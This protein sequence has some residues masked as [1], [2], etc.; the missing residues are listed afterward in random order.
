MA[1]ISSDELRKHTSE[2]SAWV[3]IKG[4]VY[5][6]TKFL[7][8]HPGG[9]KVLLR[10]CGKDASKKFAMFHEDKVLRDYGKNMVVGTVEGSSGS[11]PKESREAKMLKKM[12]KGELYG[13]LVPFGDPPWYQGQLSPYYNDSHRRWRQKVRD[14]TEKEIMPFVSEWEENYAIPTEVYRKA[15]DAGLLAG[16][17]GHSWPTEYVGEGP[18][19]YDAFHTLILL[20]ELA[21]CGAGGLPWGLSGGLVIGLPPIINFGSTFLKDKVVTDCLMGRKII[22]LCISEPWAASDVA[23]LQTTAEKQGDNFVVNGCKKWIIIGLFA[24]YFTVACRTRGA[25]SPGAGQSMFLVEK[26]ML[27]IDPDD[28]DD[29]DN[30]KGKPST[31]DTKAKP[32]SDDPKFK[33]SS[34]NLKEKPN[35]DDPKFKPSSDNL[36]EKPNSD[37][38]KFKP[39][40]DN[41]KAKPKSD[42]PK[43]KPSSDDPNLKPSSDDPKF[44]PSS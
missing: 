38:P 15:G 5:D 23:G 18:E 37:D 24:D 13:D 35:S 7:G 21:R 27:V 30:P 31:D 22:C 10:E 36:K 26:M 17:V 9:K 40:S 1:T 6:V 34:D 4:T 11:R 20:D 16:C 44:K 42:D 19:N 8:D 43:L 28:P 32:K 41:L 14:F 33:P 39:S 29:I 25:E 2:Q 3:A 12:M